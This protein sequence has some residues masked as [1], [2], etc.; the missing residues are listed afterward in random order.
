MGG[1]KLREEMDKGETF[2]FF[3]TISM[4]LIA[5]LCKASENYKQRYLF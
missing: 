3:F 2:S 4:I 1:D 5:K